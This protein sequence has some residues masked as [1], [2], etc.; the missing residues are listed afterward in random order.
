VFRH[1]GEATDA[2]ARAQGLRTLRLGLTSQSDAELLQRLHELKAAG[3]TTMIVIRDFLTSSLMS[4]ICRMALELGVATVAEH[5]AFAE[6]GAL[7]SYGPDLPD[8]FE[9]AAGYVERILK[10]AKPADLPIQ[11][12]VKFEFAV[13]L[14]TAKRLGITLTPDILF[15]ADLTIER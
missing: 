2:A 1:W 4:P 9:R 13:N 11:L 14:S 6:A 8:L 5:R 7:M 12:P 15:A 10:G 3:G